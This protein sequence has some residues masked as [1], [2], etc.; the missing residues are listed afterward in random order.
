MGEGEEEEGEEEGKE[1]IEEGEGVDQMRAWWTQLSECAYCS[2]TLWYRMM[3]LS[4][5]SSDPSKYLQS[6]NHTQVCATHCSCARLSPTHLAASS[7]SL[8][9]LMR[10]RF[11][12][13]GSSPAS[14]W[15]DKVPASHGTPPLHTRVH[16]HTH[17]RTYIHRR[18]LS[19]L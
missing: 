13:S 16:A 15:M 18:R 17:T 1:G 19:A 7:I 8:G 12:S 4:T 14:W 10:A 6:T 3:A 5:V 2:P 9:E 11:M